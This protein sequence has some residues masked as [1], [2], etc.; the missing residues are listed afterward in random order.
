[1][2]KLQP[3]LSDELMDHATQRALRLDSLFIELTNPVW[4]E[5]NYKTV[6]KRLTPTKSERTLDISADPLQFYEPYVWAEKVF[7]KLL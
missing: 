1:M 5:K 7:Q 3:E 2:F 6:A 4:Q